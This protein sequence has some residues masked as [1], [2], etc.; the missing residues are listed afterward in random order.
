MPEPLRYGMAAAP[1]KKRM[2]SRHIPFCLP[3]LSIHPVTGSD[4]MMLGI[5]KEKANKHTPGAVK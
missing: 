1:A 5:E 2:L 3:A 4:L